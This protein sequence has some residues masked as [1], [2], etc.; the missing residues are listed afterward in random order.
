MTTLK[1]IHISTKE[2]FEIKRP[3]G[4]KYITYTQRNGI[5]PS[6]L[7]LAPEKSL[8]NSYTFFDWGVGE[9]V[10]VCKNIRNN[11][12]V[13]ST[14]ISIDKYNS[15]FCAYRDTP[16]SSDSGKILI[17][18]PHDVIPFSRSYSDDSKKILGDFPDW[19][20]VAKEYSGIFFRPYDK[21]DLMEKYKD[22]IEDNDY[23]NMGFLKF[24]TSWYR[25]IDGESI[26]IWDLDLLET[27][28]FKKYSFKNHKF[29]KV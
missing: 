8:E 26:C 16:L 18:Q 21:N 14:D 19:S 15:L 28:K 17:L 6:G 10:R 4:K 20:I 9:N 29:K 24:E 7:W 12:N 3:N 13:V 23:N 22:Q 2:N 25:T 11:N 27:F 5:K 1:L